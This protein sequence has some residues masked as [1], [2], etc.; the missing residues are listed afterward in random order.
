MWKYFGVFGKEK[1]TTLQDELCK[2]LENKKCLAEKI[3]D[4]ESK[5]QLKLDNEKQLMLL[6]VAIKEN[7]EY[8]KKLKKIT[9]KLSECVN[10]D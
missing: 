4:I 7:E 8:E 2:A 5:Q 10:D 1:D 9:E 6:E 3:I